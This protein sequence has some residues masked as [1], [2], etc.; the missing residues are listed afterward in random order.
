MKS[1]NEG[2]GSV[3]VQVRGEGKVRLGVRAKHVLDTVIVS[4]GNFE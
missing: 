4:G 3:E 1:E 2:P